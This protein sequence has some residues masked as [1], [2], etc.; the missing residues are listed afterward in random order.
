MKQRLDQFIL[1]ENLA[2]TIEKAQFLIMSGNVLVNDLKIDKCGH[3]VKPD[4]KIRLL[5]EIAQ[6]VS[7]GANKL[8]GA[9]ENF[10]IDLNTRTAFDIGISTG[11]F[12][13][14]L[15]QN[16]VKAVIGV[17]VGYGDVDNKLRQD[18]RLA[19]IERNNARFL[20]Q[21]HIT[22]ATKKHPTPEIFHQPTLVVMD[23]SFISVTKIIPAL[24]PLVGPSTDFILLI[25]PQF[26]SLKSEIGDK[27][28][29]TDPKIH[30]A[31]L[32]R[33]KTTLISQG[34]SHHA[35]CTSPITGAKGNVE[36]FFWLKN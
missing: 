12:T 22:K 20:S 28:I 27:G 35:T 31:I 1:Q 33:V 9:L 6:Y 25:K 11:G 17:D 10:P 29:I 23:V 30:E 24:L 8:K 13:D 19:L 21:D 5:T 3:Q 16:G 18:S 7:R 36:F 34:L 15:L 26:E 14:Y 32:D 2:E 4:A